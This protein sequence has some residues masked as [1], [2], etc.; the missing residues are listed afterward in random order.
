M[1]VTTPDLSVIIVN[2]NVR[3]F[4]E[5]C[6]VSVFEAAE[7]YALEVI[8]VDNASADDSLDM[9]RSRFADQ[10]IVMANTDNPGFSRANNQGIA[11]ATGEFVLL[12]N[13]DTVVAQDTFRQCID[14]M[15][16]HPEAGAIGAYMID[17]AGRYLPES[18][19]ALPT[20]WVSF[21]KIFGLANLFPRSK[22]F[23]RYHL[24]FLSREET[25]E[26]EVL[27][28]AFMFMRKAVLDQIGG[29]DETFFMYGEDIDLSWRVILGGYKNYYFPQARIVHYKGEST[30]KGSLNYVR[31]FYQAMIIF[32][33]KHFAGMYQRLFVGAI[34]F[35][36][37]SRAL[38]AAC[39]RLIWKAGFPMLEAGLIYLV[40]FGVKRYW[41]YYIKFIEG[42]AY[43]AIFSW[44]YLPVYT[45]VFVALL[46]AFGAYRKPYRLRPLI[47]APLAGFVA[48]AT[49]T[50]MF[51][52]VLNFSRAIVG[53]SAVFTG[54]VAFATRA[55]LH[56]RERGTPFF[57]EAGLR[58]AVL[59]GDPEEVAHMNAVIRGQSAYQVDLV[60]VIAP[61]PVLFA[62]KEWPLLGNEADLVA[63]VRLFEIEE[64]IVGM[65]SVPVQRI[66]QHLE[67]LHNSGVVVKTAPRD[68][69][70]LIGPHQVV[71]AGNGPVGR[72]PL[73]DK[74]ARRTKRTF[75]L[76]VG[77]ILVLAFPLLSIGIRNR[78]KA[79]TGLLSVLTGKKHL[80]GYAA[81]DTQGL[82]RLQPGLLDVSQRLGGAVPPSTHLRAL[83]EDYARRYAWDLDLAVVLKGW[84]NLGGS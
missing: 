13:P 40:M 35:A 52:V 31:V 80:V 55:L 62:G 32:A 25:H 63:L 76:V 29:F 72:F 45:L 20:P 41:E 60:G 8:V 54:I 83:N 4:L 2:Y 33:K 48:I 56:W 70:F 1:T 51:S 3:H 11:R 26:I 73:G 77:G 66:M 36:V 75:D 27:S 30:Q 37:Y 79:F 82:P 69:D 53:L 18:K 38:V 84:R 7:G 17:G 24:G 15:G 19:R 43:P 74:S 47:L 81:N 34:R 28:G 6:L 16:A 65:R 22:K 67:Q 57:T 39:E 58:R 42:G 44:L 71:A 61:D 14:F 46:A 64:V 49:T 5:Q 68:T 78:G 12:L 10:V 50:Y 9:I 59:V 21:Y 23:G